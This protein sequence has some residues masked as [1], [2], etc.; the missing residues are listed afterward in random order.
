MKILAVGC[1]FTHGCELDNTLQAWP[2]VLA[3]MVNG[4]AENFGFPGGSNDYIFRTALEESLRTQY[5]LVVVQ[6]SSIDRRE[7][8]FHGKPI[9]IS[10]S[11]G[12]LSNPELKG[13][14]R[15]YYLQ[16]HDDELRLQSW[17]SQAVALQEYF[18]MQGQK[19]IFCNMMSYTDQHRSA[20]LGLWNKID[21]KYFLGWPDSALVDWMGDCPQ[22]PYGHPLELGHK[23]I[24]EKIYEH[25]RNL[26]WVS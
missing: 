13:W 19:F 3:E 7:I 2:H 15:Q 21:T 10:P 16:F 8:W 4:S 18:K 1:S 17:L 5:D 25:I 9:S 12:W 23:R 26:S 24:A 14:I 22:G 6:W 11:S 20:V